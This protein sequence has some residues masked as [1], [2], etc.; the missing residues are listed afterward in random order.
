[1]IYPIPYKLWGAILAFLLVFAGCYLYDV[2]GLGSLNWPVNTGA[3][4]AG[5]I[6]FLVLESVPGWFKRR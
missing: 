4:V 3:G 2:F 6:I 5:A 1:M